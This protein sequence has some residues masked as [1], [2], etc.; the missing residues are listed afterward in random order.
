[1]TLALL[2]FS[3]FYGTAVPVYKSHL[4]ELTVCMCK[5]VYHSVILAAWLKKKTK[6]T[7]HQGMIY[8]TNGTNSFKRQ[9]SLSILS[10]RLM[11]VAEVAQVTTPSNAGLRVRIGLTGHSALWQCM[12][13]LL[14]RC[15]TGKVMSWKEWWEVPGSA[16]LLEQQVARGEVEK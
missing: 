7:A 1:M 15:C 13:S 9:S 8:I 10:H 2:H 12:W 5:G 4:S 3:I 11:C 6:K 14:G 16:V